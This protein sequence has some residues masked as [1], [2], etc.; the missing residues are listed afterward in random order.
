MDLEITRQLNAWKTRT[1]DDKK[2]SIKIDGKYYTLSGHYEQGLYTKQHH[3][4][5]H[6]FIYPMGNGQEHYTSDGYI[7]YFNWCI[8]DDFIIR[9]H[10]SIRCFG[11]AENDDSIKL[12]SVQKDPF[13]MTKTYQQETKSEYLHVQFG[14]KIFCRRMTNRKSFHQ[15]FYPLDLVS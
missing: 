3:R 2:S 11:N 15:S 10:T 1:V 6:I 4:T 7:V 9:E 14:E 13:K 5:N 12:T 8:K